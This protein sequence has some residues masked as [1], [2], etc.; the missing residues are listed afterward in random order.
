MTTERALTA[1]RTLAEQYRLGMITVEVFRAEA[2]D[3]LVALEY[4]VRH[5]TRESLRELA[6]L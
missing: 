5:T 1:V 4:E 2:A 3:T 6:T